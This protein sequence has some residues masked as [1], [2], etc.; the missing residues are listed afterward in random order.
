MI[1]RD[2]RFADLK[3]PATAAHIRVPNLRRSGENATSLPY[4]RIS[5]LAFSSSGVSQTVEAPK[6]RPGFLRGVFTWRAYFS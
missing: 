1:R 4:H 2:R 6:K 3:T 5:I